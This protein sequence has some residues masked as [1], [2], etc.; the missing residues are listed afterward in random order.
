MKVEIELGSKVI[1]EFQGSRINIKINYKKEKKTRNNTLK[2]KINLCLEQ[3]DSKIK[4]MSLTQ[5]KKEKMMVTKDLKINRLLDWQIKTVLLI[6]IKTRIQH[7]EEEA[8]H[9]NN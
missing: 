7:N 6:K 9:R 4:I 1:I 3:K 5:K 8:D 2:I